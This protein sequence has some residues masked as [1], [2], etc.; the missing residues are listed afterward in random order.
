MISQVL[1]IVTKAPAGDIWK[2]PRQ[3]PLG[4]PFSNEA[5]VR[6]R[7][8]CHV[9]VRKVRSPVRGLGDWPNHGQ[10]GGSKARVA[11]DHTPVHETPEA[12]PYD[13]VKS[14]P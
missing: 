12:L 5:T 11:D 1:A 13:D 2:G 14:V 3:F 7:V 8:T 9:P 4:I 10:S 6:L